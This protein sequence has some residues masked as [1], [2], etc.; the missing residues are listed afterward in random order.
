[1][2][3]WQGFLILIYGLI[4]FYGAYKGYRKSRYENKRLEL[5]PHFIVY[6]AFVWADVVIFGIFWFLFSL[7]C[8]I[9]N[10]WIL[11]LLSQSLFW[12]IRGFGET[13]YWF[14]QQFSTISRSSHKDFPFSRF[15]GN[16]D[17]TVWFVMQIFMQ[18]ITVVSAIL[19]LY[20]G[21]L[22][23]GTF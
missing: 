2:E 6:G 4:G 19:S 23:L 20:F 9:L 21:K 8:I 18:C 14:N 10:D 11:F 16:D 7:V 17:Y 3:N 12:L 15:F 22:W 13:I 1:M 5:S